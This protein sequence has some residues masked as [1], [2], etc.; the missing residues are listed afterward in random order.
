[1]NGRERTPRHRRPATVGAPS[2]LAVCAAVLALGAWPAASAGQ[3][4]SGRRSPT[5]PPVP[6]LP[7]VPDVALP[8]V[9]TVVVPRPAPPVDSLL[10][11]SGVEWERRRGRRIVLYTAA[12]VSSPRTLAPSA[13]LDSL[14][15]AWIHAVALAG[16]PPADTAPIVVVVTP[17]WERFPRLLAASARGVAYEGGRG[18]GPLILLVHH[19]SAR[20]YVR[21]EVM[22]VVAPAVWGAPA[23]QW[24]AEGVATWADGRCQG[25]S[26]LAVAREL[27]QAEP[28]LTVGGLPA[29]FR[30]GI[31]RRVG[32][33][34]AAYV[35]AAS[36]VAFVDAV[37]GRDALR[38]V[39]RT[40]NTDAGGPTVSGDDAAVT[41]AWRRFVERAAAD[42]PGLAAG[43]LAAHGCG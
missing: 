15:A 4:G 7:T 21:H 18:A 13:L 12:G 17:S 1:M 38:A 25:T 2:R 31:G 36:F 3:A 11:A 42:E 9:P 41:A 20:A 40:G 32:P 29:R 8:P 30:R 35:L 22:H 23:T 39:W 5:L 33:R 28:E 19:D 6:R 14:D 34:H 26:V 16:A 37:A 10:R 24:V 27:L 43:A